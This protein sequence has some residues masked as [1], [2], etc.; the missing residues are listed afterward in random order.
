VLKRRSRGRLFSFLE[1]GGRAGIKN[2][3][4]IKNAK[5]KIQNAKSRFA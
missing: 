5:L 3:L 2:T 4:T 1:K